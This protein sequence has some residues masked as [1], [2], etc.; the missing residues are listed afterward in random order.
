M[1]SSLFL[2]C[3]VLA[4]VVSVGC[5]GCR[6]FPKGP[7]PIPPLAT[8]PGGVGPTGPIDTVP[9]VAPPPG[10]DSENVPGTDILAARTNFALMKQDREAL[11]AETVY[12]DF[13]SSVV[14]PSELTKVDRVAQVLREAPANKVTV[15]GHCDERGTEAYN[16]SLGERRA[17]AVREALVNLGIAGDRVQT[18]TYGETRPAMDGHDESAWKLNRRGEFIL[19]TP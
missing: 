8:T 2:K 14:K 12:F 11:K 3:V 7:T 18:I 6:K 4:L 9:P 1:K 15:E 5:V 19:L 13:D 17:L 16:L 10:A